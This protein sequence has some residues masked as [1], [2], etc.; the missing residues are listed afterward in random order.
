MKKVWIMAA[1]LALAAPAAAQETPAFEL[2]TRLGMT[3]FSE[4]DSATLLSVPGAGFVGA[5]VLYVTFFPS[6]SFAWEPQLY[7]QRIS[8][9]GQTGWALG[10]GAD[11]KFYAE[12]ATQNSLYALLGAALLDSSSGDGEFGLGGAVGYRWIV[13]DVL[14]VGLEARLRR[15]LD[16]ELNEIVIGVNLGAIVPRR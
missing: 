13:R 3:V 8:D 1:A 9:S 15:W 10:T 6:Q 12:S 4:D 14:G 16:S 7:I 5:P 2:G 11:F